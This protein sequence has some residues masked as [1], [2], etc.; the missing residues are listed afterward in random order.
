MLGVSSGGSQNGKHVPD[1]FPQDTVVALQALAK[2]A[3]TA[4]EPSEEVTLAV[5]STPNFQRTFTVHAAN[6]LVFQQESLPKIPGVYTVEASGLGCV[7][8]QV[9]RGPGG[10]MCVGKERLRAPL[11][12]LEPSLRLR[13]KESH[14]NRTI[15]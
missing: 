15:F 11:P 10:L 9:S 3:T 7:Y 13:C 1:C 4:Y 8:V 5:K 2:Y 6:R 12:P 14:L